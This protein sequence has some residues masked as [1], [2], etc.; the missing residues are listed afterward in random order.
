MAGGMS[1]RRKIALVGATALLLAAA[2]AGTALAA[3]DDDASERPIRGAALAR[4]T[5]AALAETG[6]GKVTGTEVGDEESRY[7]V[8]VTRPDGSQVDVQLD[9]NF[10]VVGSS[11]DDE[12]DS[13]DSD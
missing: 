8:E 11:H 7:E 13:G 2:G 4:A 12:S 9:E 10:R 6:G 1:R 5:A 3:H